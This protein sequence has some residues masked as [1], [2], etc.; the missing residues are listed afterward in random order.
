MILAKDLRVD[1]QYY[2]IEDLDKHKIKTDAKT[3]RTF[4]LKMEELIESIHEETI[5]K[6]REKINSII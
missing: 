6:I 1:T 4:V 5:K 3:A 2:V